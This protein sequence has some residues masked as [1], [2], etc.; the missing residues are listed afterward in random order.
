MS[1]IKEQLPYPINIFDFV[2]Y[3]NQNNLKKDQIHFVDV[4]NFYRKYEDFNYYK[5]YK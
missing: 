1:C 4:L 5:N 2:L 3:L